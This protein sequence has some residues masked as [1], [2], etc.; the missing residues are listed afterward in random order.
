MPLLQ[1]NRPI[2][3]MAHRSEV[4]LIVGTGSGLGSAL[5]RR[6]AKAGMGVAMAACNTQKLEGLIQEIQAWVVPHALNPYLTTTPQILA[7]I[8]LRG[9]CKSLIFHLVN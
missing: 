6:F 5:A 4:A 9:M 7:K 3:N 8:K 1:T 2:E